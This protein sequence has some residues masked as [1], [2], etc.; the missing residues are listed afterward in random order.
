VPPIPFDAVP[1]ADVPDDL[2]AALAELIARV[3]RAGFHRVLRLIYT[4]ADYPVHVVRMI[5]PGLECY[6]RDTDRIGPRLRAVLGR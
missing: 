4:P 6:S 2:D 5:V 3:R 1:T